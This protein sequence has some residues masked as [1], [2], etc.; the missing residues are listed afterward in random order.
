MKPSHNY[1][2][3]Y[4]LFGY[5]KK[6]NRPL[7]FEALLYAIADT[8]VF[9][10]FEYDSL[11][12]TCQQQSTPYAIANVK[13]AWKKLPD[14][15]GLKL[16]YRKMWD[17]EYNLKQIDDACSALKKTSVLCFK[18]RLNKRKELKALKRQTLPTA[19]VFQ[20]LEYV[21]S[22][23]E[24]TERADLYQEFKDYCRQRQSLF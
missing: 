22:Q 6:L 13:E 8:L 24:A 1:G 17:I 14:Y 10:A 11:S 21:A 12:N 19:D 16:S 23:Y 15:L 20:Y 18:K 9:D 7:I 4:K 5:R 3:L 2:E